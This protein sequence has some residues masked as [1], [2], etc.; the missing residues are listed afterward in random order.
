MDYNTGKKFEE[1]EFKEVAGG[2]YDEYGFYY[3]P[4]G[5]TII[6]LICL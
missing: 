5:S 4:D 6:Y 1:K 2:Q 3:A